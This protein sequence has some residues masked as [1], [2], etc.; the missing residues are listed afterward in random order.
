[1]K[2]YGYNRQ[3]QRGSTL[4]VGLVMLVLMTLVAIAAINMTTGNLKIVGNMQYQQ[5][6]RA[7]AQ[8]AINQV[9][10]S[11]ANTKTPSTAPTLID[12]A[13]NGTTYHVNLTQPCLKSVTALSVAEIDQSGDAQDQKVCKDDDNKTNTG[14]MSQRP[15]EAGS[16]CSRL[17]WEVT[18]TVGDTNSKAHVALTEGVTTKEKSATADAWRS[19]N[20]KVCSS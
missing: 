10:S 8:A 1:M 18:A 14:N 13:V 19:D 20:T 5:E 4:I 7:A 3:T 17:L 2:M 6:A 12:V 9:W 11:A 15:S 16:H